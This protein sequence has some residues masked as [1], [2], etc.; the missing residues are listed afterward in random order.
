MENLNKIQHDDRSVTSSIVQISDIEFEKFKSLIYDLAGITLSTGKKALV[1][2][3]LTKRLRHFQFES[4]GQYYRHVTNAENRAELQVMIDL[5]T[6]N[7]TYFFREPKHFDFLKEKLKAE[8]NRSWTTP[9]RVWSAAAST[10]EEGYTLAMLLKDV[11]GEAPWQVLGTDI[12]TRVLEAARRGLYSRER[13]QGI[14]PEYL[15]RFCLKGV[16]S[17]EGMLLIDKSLKA[18][19]EFKQ[20]N[21][22]EPSSGVG[23]FDAIFLRNVMIYFDT[24]TKTKIVT[25]LS[26]HLKPKGYFFVGHSESLN[27]IYNGF[28]NIVPSVYQKP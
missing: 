26:Q 2:S 6:T 24:E 8:A 3:R 13:A 10:G 12:S 5:L 27:G 15:A 25:K 14:P 11:L 7:E 17:Q 21:L 23:Q 16:R 28:K 1:V 22:L 19:V 18:N 20:M 4:F 9:Y